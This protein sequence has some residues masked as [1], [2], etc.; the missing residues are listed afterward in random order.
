RR[1]VRQALPR[2]A[3]AGDLYQEQRPGLVVTVFLLLRSGAGHP[4]Q[5]AAAGTGKGK[6]QIG[7]ERHVPTRAETRA[8][9]ADGPVAQFDAGDLYWT[10]GLRVGNGPRRRRVRCEARRFVCGRPQLEQS[11]KE[12][13]RRCVHREADVSTAI[14]P[15]LPVKAAL[16]AVPRA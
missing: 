6:P 8:R 4:D 15:S 3:R 10:A 2:G 9:G 1:R 13:R 12:I 14:T 16:G 5:L 7:Y 11:V